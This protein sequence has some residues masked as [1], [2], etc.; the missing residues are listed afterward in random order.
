M[1][2]NWVQEHA[3]PD[4]EALSEDNNK[5]H[6]SAYDTARVA[7]K[8]LG[9]RGEDTVKDANRKSFDETSDGTS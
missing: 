6:V 5:P 7:A 9:M 8:A 3:V 4:P 2:E 1:A